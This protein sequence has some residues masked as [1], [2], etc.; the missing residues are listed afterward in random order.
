[1]SDVVKL[2]KNNPDD[3][4][5]DLETIRKL[6]LGQ[7]TNQLEQLVHRLDNKEQFSSEIAKV[8]PQAILKSEQQSK[9][10]SEAMVPTVEEIVRLSV[11]RDINKFADA[12]F[13]VIGPAIRKSIAETIRQMLQSF[14]QALENSLSWQGVKWRFESLRTGISFAQI[15]M[16]N[17][18]IYRVEQVFLIHRKTGLLL[19]HIEI[20]DSNHQDV[21]MVSSMLSAIGDFVGDSFDVEKQQT[22][23]SIQVGD[24]SI[25]LEQGPDLLVAV[26]IRGD[27]SEN[28]RTLMQQTVEEIQLQYSEMIEVFEGDTGPF[29]ITHELLYQCV[30]T[31]YKPQKK[32]KKLIS[33]II[34]L[35]LFLIV[36]F[37]V[38]SRIYSSMQY[39]DYIATL[40]NEMGYVI[41][42]TSKKNG[43]L[44]IQGLRDPLSIDPKFLLGNSPL[45]ETD[46]QHQ[47]EPY[48]SL[49]K[50]LVIKRL[51]RILSPPESVSF[52]FDKDLLIVMGTAS[53]KW[54]ELFR[55]RIL[56]IPGVSEVDTKG[57]T[58]DEFD[59]SIFNPPETVE[60]KLVEGILTISGK[61]SNSWIEEIKT[62]VGRQAK[63]TEIDSSALVNIDAENFREEIKILEREKIFFELAEYSK[64]N[65]RND[66]K[67]IAQIIQRVINS[68]NQLSYKVTIVVQGYSDSL[69]SYQDNQKLS[70]KRAEFVAEHLIKAGVHRQYFQT[71]GIKTPLVKES[72][73]TDRKF[74]R[75]VI[76][77]VVQKSLRD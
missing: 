2:M 31:E 38:I 36:L 3:K 74:N 52:R 54:M 44:V 67:H 1:M 51:N 29:S 61:A 50:G 19:N 16:L 12:L 72:T 64:S 10:L 49:Q 9:Q 37:W 57:L 35:A 41:T 48:L 8:L 30:Q 18:L 7:E 33:K 71:K 11:K 39:N 15:V 58:N 42:R 59:M 76:F 32:K 55:N 46:V 24:C 21:D 22:L 63:I 62:S 17:S 70:L 28:L 56:T 75:R 45:E 5:R 65:A 53:P 27:A 73:E 13:P 68:A 4:Q 14:N 25:W 47:F 69:G 60:L 26:A 40:E 20:E 6:L 43:K 77:K 23:D 66:F 34:W